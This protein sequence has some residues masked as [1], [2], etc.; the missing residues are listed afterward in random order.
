MPARGV[1]L[2]CELARFANSTRRAFL[3]SRWGDGGRQL[4]APVSG[5]LAR[6]GDHHQL[7]DGEVLRGSLQV[8]GHALGLIQANLAGTLRRRT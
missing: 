8:R 4:C 7:V 5:R 3:G 1:K 6:H 2:G